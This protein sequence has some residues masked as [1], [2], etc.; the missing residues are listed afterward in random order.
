[1]NK[2]LQEIIKLYSVGSSQELQSFLNSLSKPTLMSTLID[3]LTIYFND[4]NSSKLRELATLYIAGYEPIEEKLGYNGYKLTVG[5]KVYCEVKPVNT[6]SVKRKL[7][8]G[9]SFNDYTFERFEKDRNQNL[10]ILVS[11]FVNGKLVYILEFPFSCIC[12]RIERQL[13]R[14][15]PE[16][17]RKPG[18]YLRSASF[19]FNDYKNCTDLKVIYRSDALWRFSKYI[20]SKFLSFLKSMEI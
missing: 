13:K 1:M 6:N 8:G 7:N 5:A 14:K 15:F 17:E 16:G 20:N 3:F 18:E 10:N 9:G 4:K 2:N 11:G 19:T 12:D